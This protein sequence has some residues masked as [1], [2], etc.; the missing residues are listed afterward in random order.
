MEIAIP[1]PSGRSIT[2]ADMVRGWIELWFRCCDAF[3]QWEKEAL[4]S[5]K[6]SPEDSEKHRR[7]VTA[8]IR[9]GRFLEGLLEDPD[10]PL[11]EVLPRVQERLLQLTATRE[12]LQDPMSEADFERLFKETFPGEPVPG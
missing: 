10:F 6:P 9:M 7:Q 8:F 3:Q 12:M 1:L 2:A 5:A 11:A 4:L